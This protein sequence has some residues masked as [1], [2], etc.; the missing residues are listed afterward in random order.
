[1]R[2]MSKILIAVPVALAAGAAL[3]LVAAA[4]MVFLP[5]RQ[6]NG[7]CNYDFKSVVENRPAEPVRPPEFYRARDGAELAYRFYDSDSDRILIFVHGSSYHG[8]GYDELARALS[9][10]GAAKVYLPNLR[11]HYLSGPR[12][13]DCDYLGQ[14][15]DDTADLIALIRSRG[16]TG[17]ILLGGHS[18]GGGF[19]IRFGGGAHGDLASG[20]ILLTPV[21][22]LAPIFKH[23]SGWVTADVRRMIGLQIFD[24]F[25]I[26][27]FD[28]IPVVWF[29]EP[30]QYRNG[31][32]TLV[33][34][35]RL[36]QSMHPRYDYG[37]DIAALGSNVLVLVGSDDEQNDAA[38]YAPLFHRY[39]PDVTVKILP[40]VHHL[41]ITRDPATFAAIEQWVAQRHFGGP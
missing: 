16:Q 36:N 1:M 6:D 26:T 33:Y 30:P 29:N 23:T 13:G 40:G 14:L 22:P 37:R 10:S 18:S 19:A 24:A 4:V 27:R 34:S 41:G 5:P 17:P 38:A 21:I 9:S 25:G 11:G 39:D 8:A 15:E 3:L 2:I 12:R 28:E 7:A 31:T 35:F 32:E 20:Y